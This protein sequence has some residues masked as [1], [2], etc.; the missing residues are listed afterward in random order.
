MENN[1]SNAINRTIR[2]VGIDYVREF[3]DKALPAVL[4]ALDHLFYDLGN[5]TE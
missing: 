5:V 3:R 1:E 2:V 4:I